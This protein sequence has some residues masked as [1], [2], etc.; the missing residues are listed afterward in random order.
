MTFDRNLFHQFYLENK[1]KIEQKI[2]THPLNEKAFVEWIK[3]HKNR[4]PNDDDIDQ[5]L[6]I[7][8]NKDLYES[9]EE[10]QDIIESKFY[11]SRQLNVWKK[12][13]SAEKLESEDELLALLEFYKS[14]DA[15]YQKA[16]LFRE[17]SQHVSYNE[18]ISQIALICSNIRQISTGFENVI[19][20]IQSND[21]TKSNFWVSMLFYGYLYDII[22]VVSNEDDVPVL[23]NSLVIIPDDA[24]YSGSQYSD[25]LTSIVKRYIY[26]QHRDNVYEKAHFYCAIPYISKNALK[27]INSY[28]KSSIQ[29][30]LRD[31]KDFDKIDLNNYTVQFGPY[32]SFKSFGQFLIDNDSSYLIDDVRNDLHTIYFDHKLADSLSI[33]QM[34]YALGQ[35]LF[36]EYTQSLIQGCDYSRHPILKNMMLSDDLQHYGSKY[37]CP[38]AFYKSIVYTFNGRKIK[39]LNNLIDVEY[40]N[41]EEYSDNDKEDEDEII[42]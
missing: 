22:N 29:D 37:M 1:N 2:P 9:K 30:L 5:W 36:G 38:K 24:S 34:R 7:H 8:K 33:F 20:A 6:L 40:L 23:P 27:R 16:C 11:D 26:V 17:A 28:Y 19:L 18:F 14:E 4:V 25:V 39:E 31:R 32:K 3:M 12:I 13:H 21:F 15:M 42:D 35:T 41:D 10:V